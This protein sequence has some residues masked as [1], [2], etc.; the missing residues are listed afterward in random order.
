MTQQH[1]AE[2]TIADLSELV[3]GSFPAEPRPRTFWKDGAEQPAGDVPA[4][5]ANRLAQRRWVDVTLRDWQMIGPPPS[6]SSY[7]HPDAFR[8]YLPSLLIGVLQDIR[9]LDWALELLLPAGRKRRTDRPDWVTFREGFSEAQR[10]TIRSYLT[11][12]RAMLGE[13]AGPVEQHLF[14]ELDAVWGRR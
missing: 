2:I 4:E 11:G 12:L 3:R 5:L 9:Y 13:A 8:Y 6:V 7:L 14:D 10:D 1:P